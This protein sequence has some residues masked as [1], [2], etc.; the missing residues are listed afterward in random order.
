[1]QAIALYSYAEFGVV[2]SSFLP[3]VLL[4][5]A[6]EGRDPT[7]R[8]P[9]RLLRRMARTIVA[10]SPLWR[11][12]I[13]GKA[14]SDIGHRPYVVVANHASIADPFL[15]AHLPWDMRFVA[16]QE[17]FALPLLGWL[18]KLGGDIP[19]RR[20]DERS[21]QEML[22][23][24]RA[25]LARG[26][27]VMIFPEGTRSRNGEVGRFKRG[28]F[29]VAVAAQV[30]ILPIALH[31]TERCVGKGGLSRATARAQILAPIET[32]GCSPEDV[33]ALAELTRSHVADALAG[34]LHAQ[35]VA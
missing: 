3:R 29:E 17:L 24:C 25:T 21:A 13:E 35:T 12:S 27:S 2:A 1:M 6:C 9:G 31:G 34:E 16:K 30:P 8:L 28:A 18:L 22:A 20:G 26:L 32:A 7:H 15:L 11:F 19:V 23:A 4:A 33:P 14:P 10:G 5:R